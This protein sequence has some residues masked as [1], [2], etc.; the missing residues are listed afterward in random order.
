MALVEELEQIEE[1]EDVY[2]L[3]I[4]TEDGGDNLMPVHK[5][6]N[7][8][9]RI[10]SGG[11]NFDSKEKAEVAYKAYLA[12]KHNKKDSKK[13]EIIIQTNIQNLDGLQKEIDKEIDRLWDLS[14]V[15]SSIKRVVEYFSKSGVRG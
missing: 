8:K 5:C 4:E 13:E 11:C 12:K 2:L 10:G 3:E 6:P 7:G 14:S 15:L 9:Y 1:E